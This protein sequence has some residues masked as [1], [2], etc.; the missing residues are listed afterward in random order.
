[1]IAGTR[2]I[3]LIQARLA[4]MLTPIAAVRVV[5]PPYE[6]VPLRGD[7][8][9]P[10]AHARRGPHLAARDGGAGGGATAPHSRGMTRPQLGPSTARRRCSSNAFTTAHGAQL[11]P[12]R[13]GPA[14]AASTRARSPGARAAPP[15]TRARAAGPITARRDGALDAPP[16]A[17]VP[18][19]RG[20]TEHLSSEPRIPGRAGRD[21]LGTGGYGRRVSRRR[22]TSPAAP[23]RP[24]P[25][26]A[27]PA[28]ESAR[29]TPSC[30]AA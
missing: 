12:G 20:V 23:A 2:R 10:G 13:R 1:M 15:A 3:A 25:T 27:A 26:R 24:A 28:A 8:V 11:H 22:R 19:P 14:A 21:R 29:P 5:E 9:A 6:A 30:P 7:V 17:A 18:S 16:R 4:R